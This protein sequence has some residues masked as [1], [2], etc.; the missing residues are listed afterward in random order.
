[1]HACVRAW[2][3]STVS[4]CLVWATVGT[5]TELRPGYMLEFYFLLSFISIHKKGYYIYG[6]TRVHGSNKAAAA[7]DDDGKAGNARYERQDHGQARAPNMK[8]NTNDVSPRLL[9]TDLR[10]YLVANG[11]TASDY[12]RLRRNL[13]KMCVKRKGC[14]PHCRK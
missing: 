5:W 9:Q 1:M 4:G 13:K 10:A 7:A 11:Y 3:S 8:N 6:P 14:Q 12:N 2:E